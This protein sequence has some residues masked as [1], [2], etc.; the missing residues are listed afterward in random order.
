MSSDYWSRI[1]RKKV[2]APGRNR[3]FC[4]GGHGFCSGRFP[5]LS[6]AL[7]DRVAVEEQMSTRSG[8]FGILAGALCLAFSLSPA[9][10]AD[11]PPLF[12]ANPSAGWF[13][14][15]R[16]FIQPASGPGPVRLDPK[17][18]RVTNDDFRATGVQPTPAVGDADNPILQPWAAE[19][20]RKRN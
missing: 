10:A 2:A 18:P 13:A 19:R 17:Y 1:G 12:T 4:D 5:V 8:N 6:S 15:T 14:Y 3:P 11:A 9:M 7:A 20:V 16:V